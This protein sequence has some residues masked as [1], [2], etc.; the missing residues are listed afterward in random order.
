MHPPGGTGR[1]LGKVRCF[2]KSLGFRLNWCYSN[3]MRTFLAVVALGFSGFA[4]A[5]P[6]YEVVDLTEMFG[7][8]SRRRRLTIRA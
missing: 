3:F 6:M 8:G 7:I 4:G 2:L 5:Q 1:F